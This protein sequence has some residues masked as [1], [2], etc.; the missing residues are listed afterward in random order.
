MSQSL[1]LSVTGHE[2]RQQPS[3][4][5]VYR[6]DIQAHLRQWQIYKRYSDFVALDA[7]LKKQTTQTPPRPLPPK[8]SFSLIR[9]LNQPKVIAE[10][11][12]ALQAYLR[13]ILAA[14]DPSW[15]DSFPFR[16][17]LALPTTSG[18]PAGSLHFTP[19][20]WLDEHTDLQS[21]IR[22]IRADIN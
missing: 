14:R 10:R 20:S 5:T 9:T 19:T 21:L 13:A 7:D 15:R 18:A 1:Q 2:T 17:F 16:N 8:H 6:I 11:E 4:H 12:S 3:P 22:D